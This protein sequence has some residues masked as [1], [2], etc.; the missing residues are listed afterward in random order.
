MKTCH[1]PVYAPLW[2]EAEIGPCGDFKVI[3]AA[4]LEITD[5]IGGNGTFG[6]VG[7]NV[8]ASE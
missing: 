1:G 2:G 7:M 6:A 4:G 3:I 8:V 5:V